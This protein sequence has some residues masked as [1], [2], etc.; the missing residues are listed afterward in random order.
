MSSTFVEQ[1]YGVSTTPCITLYGPSSSID[2]NRGTPQGDKLSAFV[3]TL[4]LEPFLWWLT[5]GRNSP[6]RE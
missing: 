5:V 2:I 1:L 6:G 3:F 4:F